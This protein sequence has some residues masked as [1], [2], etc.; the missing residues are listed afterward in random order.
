MEI[1][2]AFEADNRKVSLSH[3]VADLL[4]S[5]AP[6]TTNSSPVLKLFPMPDRLCPG[7]AFKYCQPGQVKDSA[8]D[9]K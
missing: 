2:A 9:V 6:L 8:A 1:F 4:F 3:K 7:P 5:L